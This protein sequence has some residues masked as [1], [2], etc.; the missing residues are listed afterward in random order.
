MSDCFIFNHLMASLVPRGGQLPAPDDLLEHLDPEQRDV[1]TAL[2]GPVCVVAG[3]GTGKTRAITHRI[4]YGVASGVYQPSEVLAVTFTTRAAGEMR[5]RLA[6]LGAPGVQARTFHSA[7]LRQARYF[8]P[9]VYGTEFPE[10]VQSKFGL[11]AEAVRRLGLRADTPLL[12]DLSAEIEWAKVSNIRPAD[13]VVASAPA[14]REVAD[15]D[16]ATVGSLMTAYEDVK[17]ERGRIDMEDILLVTAAILADDE[18][19]AAQVRRQ[20]RW[21]V[22]DEFQDVNPLQSTLLDLWLGGRDEI[23]VVGDPRQTIYS[24]AGAS[25]KILASFTRKYPEAE[26]IELVRNY[27][28]TPQ[29]VAVANAVFEQQ[30]TPGVRLT[31]Q[32]E[33]GDPVT[34]VGHPDE[35]TEAN[36]VANEIALLNRRGTPYREMAVLFR[37]NAQSEAFEE[38]LGD[39]GIPY[40][41]R[42]VEGFFRRAEVRQAITLLRGAARGGQDDAGGELVDEVRAVLASMGHTDEAPSGAGAVRDRWESLHAIVSMAT[43]LTD[44]LGTEADLTALVADLDRRAESAHAPTA[45]GVTLATLHSAKGLEWDAVF[46]VGVHEGMVPSVHADTPQAIDEERRLFYVGITRARHTLVIS[47]ASARK[48]GGRGNRRPS[49][50]LDSLLPADHEARQTA[51]SPRDRKVARCRVCKRPLAVG[52]ER[53]RGRCDDCPATYDEE[54]YEKLRAWRTEQA[55]EAKVPAYVVFTDAT[56]QAIAETKP[57]DPVA[58]AT[59]PGVGPAKL[60]RYADQVLALVNA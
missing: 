24:F 36:A 50:F 32:A 33:P 17:R 52:A 1:A 42:G 13:Y 5:N 58:L 28:S 48:P 55:G 14:R 34:Y 16:P 44:A 25:P 30:R 18:R 29:V 38:A 12:R 6:L 22:V 20:Y 60:E 15:L 8:W 35:T 59:V 57:A 39:H 9:Q 10:I 53:K 7:A 21:F 23:C 4:A 37:I 31:S 46:C 45:D 49:R 47:W 51:R 43:D 11:V 3:A 56:L 41:L 40:T 2:R 26:R 19:V 27:R 54:L